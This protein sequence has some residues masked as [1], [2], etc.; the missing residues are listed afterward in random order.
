VGDGIQAFCTFENDSPTLAHEDKSC[1]ASLYVQH[2]IHEKKIADQTT[3][4]NRN[5][6]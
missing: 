1:G 3:D 5:T 2:G 6:I 4:K